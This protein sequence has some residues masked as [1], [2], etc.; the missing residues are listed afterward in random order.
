MSNLFEGTIE[1]QAL[2]PSSPTDH[3][4][5]GTQNGASSSR[6]HQLGSHGTES[7]YEGSRLDLCATAC[8]LPSRGDQ[9]P[10]TRPNNVL[11]RVRCW[12]ERRLDHHTAAV[13]DAMKQWGTADLAEIRVD[14]LALPLIVAIVVDD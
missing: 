11:S 5:V 4:L 9:S 12:L 8:A 3:S 13:I 1:I 14:R 10:P 2:S 6:F 7:R